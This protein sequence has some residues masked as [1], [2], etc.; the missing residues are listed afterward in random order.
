MEIKSK[1]GKILRTTQKNTLVF[2]DLSRENLGWVDFRDQNMLGV[3]LNNSY[4]RC[5]DFRRSN[6]CH[7]NL[8]GASLVEANLRGA[9]LCDADFRRASLR[10]AYLDNVEIDELTRIDSTTNISEKISPI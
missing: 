6:L 3:S 2:E 8:C 4:L 5:A 1:D 7:A 10:G 9:N